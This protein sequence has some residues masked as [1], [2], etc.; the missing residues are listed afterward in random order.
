MV[1]AGDQPVLRKCVESA[2]AVFTLEAS[3]MSQETL[4]TRLSSVFWKLVRFPHPPDVLQIILSEVADVLAW[5]WLPNVLGVWEAATVLRSVQ[6]KWAAATL[7]GSFK[8]RPS[9]WRD[10]AGRWLYGMFQLLTS[11]SEWW[12]NGITILRWWDWLQGTQ[13]R[14]MHFIDQAEPPTVSSRDGT[15][16]LSSKSL[17]MTNW[18][19]SPLL[20]H[21][22]KNYWLA[23]TQHWIWGL[24][25]P[26]G[27]C[28]VASGI[29]LW[30][31]SPLSALDQEHYG[32]SI[33][34]LVF[35]VCLFIST[36]L[37]VQNCFCEFPKLLTHSLYW[38]T[39]FFL[40]LTLL[41]SQVTY[42]SL[43][44]AILPT[45]LHYIYFE[46]DFPTKVNTHCTMSLSVTWEYIFF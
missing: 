6:A 22:G 15:Q 38:I 30:I 2:R 46:T 25:E 4:L 27:L 40:I 19:P 37:L 43:L 20:M 41:L 28:A 16:P 31:R 5:G 9:C 11:Y 34:P 26:S 39:C 10:V 45:G 44:S 21:H 29:I 13:C 17:T 23:K 42:H 35:F 18:D 1:Y 36:F 32:Q 12:D 33:G 24:V 8:C 3:C 14:F 7:L